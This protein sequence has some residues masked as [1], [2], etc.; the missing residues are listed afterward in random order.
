MI[1]HYTSIKA[2]NDILNGYRDSKDKEHVV[3]W[4]SSAY[5]MNDSTEMQYGW[6]VLKKNLETYELEHDVSID[7]RLSL[8]MNRI[9]TSNMNDVFYQHFYRQELTPFFLSFSNNRDDLTMWSMYGDRGCGVCLCFDES[10][11][12]IND[13]LLRVFL[14]LNVLYINQ[15]DNDKVSSVILGQV[16]PMQYAKYL[17]GSKWNDI[18][19]ITAIGSILPMISVYVKDSSFK[20]EKEARIPFQA[21]NAQSVYFRTSPKQNLI[22]YVKVPIP[23]ECLQEIIISPCIQSQHIERGLELDLSL[24]GFDIPISFSNVPYRNY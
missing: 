24:C 6:Q 4:A 7:K 9:E 17:S 21:K 10:L 11:L 2:L 12:E 15:E 20:F 5:A 14:L 1:Y 8:Y 23:K 16:V 18:D 19:K 3:F 13:D 22:P